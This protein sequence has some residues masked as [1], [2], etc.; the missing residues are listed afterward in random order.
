[1][2][3]FATVMPVMVTEA[4]RQYIKH[5]TDFRRTAAPAPGAADGAGGAV[6]AGGAAAPRREDE[7]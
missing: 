5:S 2:E 1:M 6:G 4:E 3:E 7:R